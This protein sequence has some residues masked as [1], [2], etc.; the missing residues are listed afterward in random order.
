MF[1]PIALMAGA[2]ITGCNE[3]DAPFLE[4]SSREIVLEAEAC[5][6]NVEILS[7][8]EWNINCPGAWCGLN[9]TQ[10][11]HR[12]VLQISA[13]PNYSVEERV[14]D[15]A[16]QYEGGIANLTVRQ[17][18][19]EAT[20][21]LSE[22]SV[23][24][25]R[26][27][28]DCN[29]VIACNNKWS[30]V[31]SKSW[32]T[33][34]PGEGIGESV[35]TISVDDNTTENERTATVTVK[36]TLSDGNTIMRTIDVTQ[37]ATKATIAVSPKE[38]TV[39]AL[40]EEVTVK[41]ISNVDWEV[42]SHNQW[43]MVDRT[44]GSGDGV[45][46]VTVAD[47]ASG[48]ERKGSISVFT[49]GSSETRETH[50]VSITQSADQH[51]LEVPVVEYFFDE[52]SNELRVKYL[53][54]GLNCE[55]D[56][57]THAD[58]IT[59][60]GMSDDE[61]YF[62]I[63]P[64]E[65]T[66]ART[67]QVSIF[68]KGHAG[69]PI[70]KKVSVAQSPT[71][72]ILD[73]FFSDTELD[74]K[75]EVKEFELLSTLTPVTVKCSSDWC[76]VKVGPG[77]DKIILDADANNTGKTR[78][79]LVRVSITIPTGEVISK[80]FTVTQDSI[81]LSFE[82]KQDSY[83][84]Q[85]QG[86]TITVELVSASAWSVKDV[87]DLPKWVEIGTVSGDYGQAISV[88]IASNKAI[89][90]RFCDIIFHN[91]MLNKDIVLRLEQEKNPSS[92]LS[93]YKYLGKGYDVAGEYAADIDVRAFVLDWQKL[94]DADYI[95]DI[96]KP[97]STYESNIYGKTISE[98][99]EGMSTSASLGGSFKGFGA[100]VKVSFSESSY[101]SAEN[102]FGLFRHTTK[103]LSVKLN[104]HLT[105]S[106]LKS[107]MTE[108]AET[109]INGAMAAKDVILTYGTHIITGFILGGSLDYTMSADRTSMG[110]ATDWGMAMSGGFN[111][112]G[113]GVNVGA[114][115]NQYQST[116]N[117]SSNFESR[118]IVRGGS[119]QYASGL[120]SQQAKDNWL[121]SLDDPQLWALVDYDGSM[122]IPI[123]EFANTTA[124]RNELQK[125][126]TDY[127]NGVLDGPTSTH[128]MFTI[129]NT[130]VAYLDG[131]EGDDTAD[132]V[133]TMKMTLDGNEI[134]FQE[135]STGVKKDG[136]Q[137]K[138]ISSWGIKLSRSLTYTKDHT[139]EIRVDG[140]EIDYGL[141]GDD[142]Y[143]GSITLRFQKTTGKWYLGA[144]DV[145]GSS[146][147]QLT[148]KEGTDNAAAFRFKLD[149]VNK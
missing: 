37:K 64:H 144:N 47:N 93:D 42:E 83:L 66:E 72:Y 148:T 119:S 28:D 60:T 24:F 99:Q 116:K 94:I 117:S 5:M 80:D 106:Q 16:V 25:Y 77:N 111:L 57:D 115:Y 102:E 70:T 125:V 109:D 71:E 40:E 79:A 145:T 41:V 21:G 45:I 7:N 58:W 62:D 82:F 15:I 8:T 44:S 84:V 30:A 33:V 101:M 122:L 73:I 14:V 114:E 88:K 53:A 132:L 92:P 67:A 112:A 142:Y 10:G 123:W 46:T 76:D 52:N 138:D 20:L 121:A 50:N 11:S 26:D 36:T 133:W 130:H 4:L 120:G 74:P 141:N 103:K 3:D 54:G 38:K 49:G 1:I 32:C 59:L 17:K 124:R 55:V 146:S 90:N 2:V 147:I 35:L 127:I 143:S 39:G 128:K 149:W 131:D 12:G 86:G 63:A 18:G 118:L 51:F 61:L 134:P 87:A 95:A 105:A 48:K 81:D 113:T 75:G 69:T 19:A 34:S 22:E 129:T 68:T 135:R 27:A 97:G 23:T 29:V 89:M 65:G 108:Q 31:S 110:T 96:L 91:T 56:A 126:A 85:Y 140:R 13:Q 136:A 43:I 9:I 100:Q 107:C 139:L 137:W 98:Y 104:P 6:H 78:S